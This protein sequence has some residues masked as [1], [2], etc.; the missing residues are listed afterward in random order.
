MLLRSSLLLAVASL[1][2]AQP[3][4]KAQPGPDGQMNPR[5]YT[6][7]GTDKVIKHR[8]EYF[9]VYSTVKSLR[10]GGV[11]LKSDPGVPLPPGTVARFKNR[12]MAITGWES[13]VEQLDVATGSWVRAKCSEVYVH[14]YAPVTFR[15]SK[16][17]AEDHARIDQSRGSHGTNP[18]GKP[19]PPP[20]PP[21]PP[22]PSGDRGADDAH[23]GPTG[24]NAA[25]AGAPPP[26]AQAIPLVQTISHAEGNE[27][28]GSFRG[29]SK[30]AAMLLD[31]PATM[32]GMFHMINTKNPRCGT[33]TDCPTTGWGPGTTAPLPQ[34]SMAPAGAKY[35]GL[36]ECPCSTRRG[37]YRTT[38]K[39]MY[40]STQSNSSWSE[41]GS[42]C[43]PG[44]M[45]L[46]MKNP[47]C[48]AATYSGGLQ[49]CY[50]G[51][52]LLDADQTIPELVTQFRF[53]IRVYFTEY[54]PS[55]LGPK[56]DTSMYL[57]WETE[58]WETE[59]DVLK[60]SRGVPTGM[61][62]RTLQT[63]FK[64]IDLFGG[65]SDDWGCAATEE[66]CLQKRRQCSYITAMDCGAG[67]AVGE[68]PPDGR[69]R[70][71]YASMHQHVALISGRLINADTGEELCKTEPIYGGSDTAHD[72]EGYAVGIR[73][74][75]WNAG[76]DPSLPPAPVLTLN[77][78]LTAISEY[79][80]TAG[81]Y[82]V[83]ALWEMRGGWAP[84]S[85][86]IP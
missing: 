73:P 53:K 62:S 65:W 64:A 3:F 46:R 27:H 72:E 15:S 48:S 23:G 19:P 12:T 9:E 81:H 14:H 34:S 84:P 77:T 18:S 39:M 54:V 45:L 49:C 76:G 21:P 83:M 69:F 50:D 36:D 32:Y 25:T 42:G 41:Y 20:P 51:M 6:A 38:G 82:G 16:L 55:T 57:F 59:Y 85:D 78:T 29:L 1:T 71:L 31:S 35:S 68:L 28:R 8:G 47:T 40:D 74:C 67:P 66:Q 44:G 61:A 43:K 37:D 52:N 7:A 13:D 24:R 80:S 79:N 33:S 4:G 2:A 58:E 56:Y 63:T 30:G 17:K 5:P 75:V 26:Q 11:S 60:A 22:L 86:V 10:Y 70:L